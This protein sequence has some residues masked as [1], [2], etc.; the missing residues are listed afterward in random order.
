MA[1]VESLIQ[2]IRPE[3][4]AC[5]PD[6]IC[7]SPMTLRL[8]SNGVA[9]LFAWPISFEGYRGDYAELT[10]PVQPGYTHVGAY[11]TTPTSLP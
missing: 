7:V 6:D 11:C 8:F 5:S 2:R 9:M 3:S 10:L 1:V 4:V